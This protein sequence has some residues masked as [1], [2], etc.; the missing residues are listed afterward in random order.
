LPGRKDLSG[1]EVSER[2]REMRRTGISELMALS[3]GVTGR[4]TKELTTLENVFPLLTSSLFRN[5][6]GE[7]LPQL[8]QFSTYSHAPKWELIP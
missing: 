6:G 2:E 8:Q 4:E 5:G 1:S 3:N 7:S